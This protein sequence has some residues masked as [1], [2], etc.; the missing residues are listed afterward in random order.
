MSPEQANAECLRF[1]SQEDRHP[2]VNVHSFALPG[3]RESVLFYRCIGAGAH[4]MQIL[5]HIKKCSQ[6]F[7][8]FMGRAVSRSEGTAG[9]WRLKAVLKL[10][11]RGD[12]STENRE[13][14]EYT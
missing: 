3:S 5:L 4:L 8:R 9:M 12:R 11:W 2:I 7:A 10:R 1:S 14:N 13:S 6:S